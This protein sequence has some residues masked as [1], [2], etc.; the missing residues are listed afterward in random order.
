MNPHWNANMCIKLV[1]IS[2]FVFI[3][4]MLGVDDKILVPRVRVLLCLRAFTRTFILTLKSE[5]SLWLLWRFLEYAQS[6]V[7]FS[8]GRM[9]NRGSF[10]NILFDTTSFIQ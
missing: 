5:Q 9:K 7:I 10:S 4:C 6:F 1:L 2:I 8:H 3:P